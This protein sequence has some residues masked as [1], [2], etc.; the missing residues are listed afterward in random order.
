M[1]QLDSLELQQAIEHLEVP[2]DL[3]DQAWVTEVA[4]VDEDALAVTL[5]LVGEPSSAPHVD[6]DELSVEL[7]ADVHYAGGNLLSCLLTCVGAKNVDGLVFPCA[8]RRD[9]LGTRSCGHDSSS[10]PR[11]GPRAHYS[12]ARRS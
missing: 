4:D 1:V 7:R 12:G 2:L 10:R 8:M 9:F 5:D 11:N 3:L 6:L